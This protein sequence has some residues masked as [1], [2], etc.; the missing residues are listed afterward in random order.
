M[1]YRIA[2][3]GITWGYDASTAEAAVRDVAQIGYNAYETIGG[4][5][6]AYEAEDRDFG[7]LLAR[8]D[9]G[10]IGTY[11]G[12]GFRHGEDPEPD[13]DNARR[14]LRRA[15]ELGAET[16]LLAAGSRRDGPCADPAGW[17]HIADAFAEIAR[18]AREQGLRTAVH[19]HTGTLLE[20]R[21]DI[22]AFFRAA[23]TDLLP[24][25]PDTGQ[26]AKAGDDPVSTL[27]DYR[28]I[29]RHV[30]LKDYGG[31][32]ETGYLGYAPIG[33]GVIDM[34]AIFQILEEAAFA[35]WVTV[36]LDGTPDAPR[37][38]LVAAQMSR[39]CLTDILGDRVTW[40]RR[41]S[42]G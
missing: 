21:Q 35:G 38:P 2:H 23:D 5:I 11:I 8:F 34:P 13:I 25:A 9:I 3:S 15:R 41:P 19:P 36:E 40:S 7:E 37:P 1:Q 22:D 29:I 6:E 17:R 4:V 28:D 24:F 32:R 30:H 27:R 31:G 33:S 12:T 20:T 10:L 16:A 26:I 39:D 18:I 14:W 42:P